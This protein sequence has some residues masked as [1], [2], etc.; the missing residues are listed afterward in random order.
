MI[1]QDET[2]EYQFR[3]T[4]CG[5][6]FDISAALGG[7][8]S[9]AHAGQSQSYNHKKKVRQERELS[10]LLHKEVITLYNEKF[11]KQLDE[12]GDKSPDKPDHKPIA[13]NRNTIK[14]MKKEIVLEDPRFESLRDK[15]EKK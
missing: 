11:G 7:H 2:R 10:R 14:R 9:K 1:T 13:I 15:Y 5:K 6:G 8:I 4:F 12:N 3:C